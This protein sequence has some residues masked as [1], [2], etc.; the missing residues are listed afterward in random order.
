MAKIVL[1]PL[2]ERP[3][4]FHFPV[5][6]SFGTE[7][8]V[9][10]PPFEIMGNKKEKGDVDAIWA[11][12]RKEVQDASGII[13]SFDTLLYG[14]IVP[15]RLHM[16]TTDTLQKRLENV[17]MLKQINP[18]LVVFGYSLIMRN[19]TYSSAD[20]EP[21]YY[22]LFGREIHRRG[23]IEHKRLLKIA[24]S[25]EEKEYE[26][27]TLKLPPEHFEDYTSRRAKNIQMNMKI[28]DLVSVGFVDFL[29]IPQDD[30]SP[31]GLTAIDQ[32]SV[33]KHI[34]E[35]KVGMKVYMYPGADEVANT[36]L[37]RMINRFKDKTPNVFLKYTSE[38]AK[39]VIPLYE[40]R[41]LHETV[42]YQI[43]A[44]GG[45]V[46]SSMVEADFV[47]IVNAPPSNMLNASQ[48]HLRGIEYDAFRN[49]TEAVVYAGYVIRTLKKQVVIADVAYGNGADLQLIALLK[50]EG[51]LFQLAGY[52]GW[53][54]SSNTLGTCIPQGM[55]HHHYG[56]TQDHLDFLSLR[57]TEDAGYCGIVRQAVCAEE[58]PKMGLGYFQADGKRGRVSEI[59]KKRLEIFLKD[60]IED[61]TTSIEILDCHM[62]WSR[63]F[64]V[65]LKTRIIRK[66][67]IEKI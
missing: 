54:T 36:L 52:A 38:G 3:C 23:V 21:D 16:E 37:S 35:K 34:D 1:I 59:V 53:N 48:S 49:L 14:G 61:E 39:M 4:N 63:M 31:Y 28:I 40:D 44:A 22:G 5:A 20:E 47:L 51:L 27:I 9:I 45:M 2:D 25:E 19:P 10:V 57:Y 67:T 62:P 43:I 56:S 50:A 29:I 64:E 58:L 26:A 18:A 42:K 30:A 41:P 7:Y 8:E 13:V 24:S 11:W 6:L 46:A 32:I 60:H 65:G 17:R 15:S 66:Q 33:R 55:I 12:A